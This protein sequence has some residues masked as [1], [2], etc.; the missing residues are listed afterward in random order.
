M[1]SLNRG[2]KCWVCYDGK[3]GRRTLGEVVQTRQQ[4]HV[5]VK[6][7]LWGSDDSGQE[8]LVWFKRKRRKAKYGGPH[9][10]YFG[11]HIAPDTLMDKLFGERCPGDYYSLVPV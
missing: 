11:Y 2:S 7:T 3:F 6:S 8:F 9:H 10:Y 4:H 1:T 5:L